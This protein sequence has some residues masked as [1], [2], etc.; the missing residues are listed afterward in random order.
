MKALA[1][2]MFTIILEG[3]RAGSLSRVLQGNL[4][5]RPLEVFL[6]DHVLS[7]FDMNV[8]YSFVPIPRCAITV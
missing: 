4:N 1:L 8:T 3:N 6:K 2:I 5:N 7:K